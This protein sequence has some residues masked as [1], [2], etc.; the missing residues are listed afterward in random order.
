MRWVYLKCNGQ[1]HADNYFW[2]VKF[3]NHKVARKCVQ[4]VNDER[5]NRLHIKLLEI[6]KYGTA[7]FMLIL[8][9][10]G[11]ERICMYNNT[12]FMDFLCFHTIFLYDFEKF[13]KRNLLAFGEQDG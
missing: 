7:Y 12:L 10:D 13:L 4:Y 11:V 2:N 3:Q 8:C 5:K 6:R 1:L 9:N